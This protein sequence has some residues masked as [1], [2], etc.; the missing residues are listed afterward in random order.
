M[1]GEMTTTLSKLV[2]TMETGAVPAWVRDAV[3]AKRAE[4][5]E[6][7]GKTGIYT[8]HGPSGEVVEIRA[9]KQ[10]AAA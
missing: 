4:I 2:E 1:E 10:H 9:E 5:A 7:L 8:L 3:Q 6:E